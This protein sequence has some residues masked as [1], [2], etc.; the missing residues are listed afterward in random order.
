MTGRVSDSPGA[1]LLAGTEVV[2]RL[3]LPVPAGA[4]GMLTDALLVAYGPELRVRSE[5]GFLLV[6]RP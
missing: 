3:L 1:E 6:F 5:A 2:A 4:L